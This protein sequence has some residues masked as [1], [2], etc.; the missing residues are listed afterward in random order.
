MT[1]SLRK[2]IVF[3]IALTIIRVAFSYPEYEWDD[4][5][6]GGDEA[7][8][9]IHVE[10][11]LGRVANLPCDIESSVK[12]HRVYMVLWFRESAGKPIYSFD[13]RGRP[14][15]KAIRWSDQNTFGPRANFVTVK[16]PASLQLENV[17]LDDEGVYRCR[18]DF[19]NAPTRNFQINLT[20]IVP[21]HQVIIYDSSGR[22]L[23][24]VVGPLTEGA[25]AFLTCEVRGGKPIPMVSWY[26]ENTVIESHTTSSEGKVVTSKIDIPNVSRS[27]LNRTY[28]C[29]ATNTNL[30][31][32]NRKTVRIELHLRPLSVKILEKPLYLVTNDEYTLTCEVTGSRPHA[33]LTWWKAESRFNRTKIVE[34]KNETVSYTSI[35]FAPRPEDNGHLLKCRAENPMLTNAT[36]EDFIMLNV[37]YPPIV[38]LHFGNSLNPKNIK[39]NDDVYFECKVRS[40][41][42]QHRI[43]W[44][45]NG[46]VVTQNVS[47]G[48]ILSTQSLVLQGVSYL[49]SGKYVCQAAN[50]RGETSSEPTHLRV[51]Y[52]PKCKKPELTIIG[53]SLGEVLYVLCQVDADPN[54]VKF[55][56]Q[57]NNSAGE[58]TKVSNS[59]YKTIN[60]TTS[61]LTYKP[62]SDLDYGTLI[63]WADNT[64]GRQL[65]PCV[66]HLVPADYS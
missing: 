7:G 32:P 31:K 16:Y 33:R 57:F 15:D 59:M 20:V 1:D 34:R 10:S 44:F 50:E 6:E 65:E 2:R 26:M 42:G 17:Q 12:D 61:E 23:T 58:S 60:K 9:V 66:F 13:V 56:W 19:R 48:I 43:T 35:T 29:Q 5:E 47:S 64:I 46:N 53:A 37:L 51:Q 52:V 21:P 14:F 36:L 63:C 38:S 45:H 55:L 28:T 41:P 8:A 49:S 40:N 11:V 22:E 54:K 24:T 62:L 39:E 25:D 27:F 4:L 18:V 30:I 3:V